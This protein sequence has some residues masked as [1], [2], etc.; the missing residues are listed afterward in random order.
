MKTQ[1]YIF[2]LLFTTILGI[3]SLFAQEKV[4]REYRVRKNEVPDAA[5][6]WLNDAF[7]GFK[8]VKWYL[9]ENEVGRAY[10]A[11]IKKD[12]VHYSIEFDMEGNVVDVEELM[13]FDEI[14]AHLYDKIAAYLDEEFMRYKVIRFQK[15]FSGPADVLEDYFDEDETEGVTVK[16]EMEIEARTKEGEQLYELL[17]DANGKL[18]RQRTMA[19]PQTNN[20]DY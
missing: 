8:R 15:Q 16:F 3:P 1:R 2:C 14:P 13:E 17:F 6:L 20:L 5:R 11:K 10:E 7:E 18:V 19:I 12:R 4:E 9:E